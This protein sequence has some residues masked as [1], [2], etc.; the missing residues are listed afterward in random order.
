MNDTCRD[1]MLTSPIVLRPDQTLL[2]ALN[3]IH[4]IGVRYLP[5]VDEEGNFVGI[6]S[7]LTL[8]RLL[9]PQALSIGMGKK[10]VD[11]NFMRTSVEELRERLASRSTETISRHIIKED[12]PTLTP[13][14]SIMEAIHLLHAHHAHVI[15]TAAPDSRKFVGI[16]TINGLLNHILQNNPLT[17]DYA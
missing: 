1:I 10:P 6:F 14:S 17:S 11:L 9:L 4:N 16:V 13:E 7:S 2:E 15:I 12:I 8:L 5:V 3:T